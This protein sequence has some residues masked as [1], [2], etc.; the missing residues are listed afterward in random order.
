MIL[1]TVLTL[2]SIALVAAMVLYIVAKKFHVYE[3]PRIDSVQELLPAAN[4]GGCGF[5]GC[6]GFAE[7]LVRGADEG[8]IAGLSCPPGGNECAESVG[9][10]LGMA[11]E[12]GSPTVAVLRC[13][14]SCEKSIAKAEY[15]GPMN[16]SIAHTLHSGEGGCPTGCLG[17]GDCVIACDFDAMYMDEETKL[18]VILED[19]CTSCNGCV[20]ACPRDL[21]EIRP[22]GKKGKRIWI[23]CMNEEKGGASKKNCEVAC[24]GCSKCEKACPDNFNAIEM[25]NNRAYIDPDKCTACGI[26]F[27][28]CPTD[29]ISATWEPKVPK[30]L[31]EEREAKEAKRK[32]K[33]EQQASTEA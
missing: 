6:R 11:V 14:G 15:D 22:L 13:G 5:P 1:S 3:D 8:D 19:K 4:C 10:F 2:G 25:I 30:A 21:I 17:C 27:H 24:I 31:R 32:A 33:E 29:A 20:T 18:P 12:A 9:T 28:Y 7:A 26:C 23:N 16:C